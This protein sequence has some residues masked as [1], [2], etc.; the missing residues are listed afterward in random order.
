MGSVSLVLLCFNT[1]VRKKAGVNKPLHS[2]S[3]PARKGLSLEE[4][5]QTGSSKHG[6][7]H[8]QRLVNFSLFIVVIF[9][10]FEIGRDQQLPEE[11]TLLILTQNLESQFGQFTESWRRVQQLIPQILYEPIRPGVNLTSGGH[12]KLPG[13]NVT[14]HFPV[15]LV[16][17]IVSSKLEVWKG[18]ECAANDFRCQY[19]GSTKMLEAILLRKKC[20]LEHIALNQTTG[21]DPDGIKIRAAEGMSAADF[22]IGDYW[23][24]ERVIRNLADIGYDP[25]TMTLE[26]YDWR[27][28]NLNL[29]KRDGFFTKMKMNIEFLVR[30]NEKKVIIVGHSMGGIVVLNFLSWVESKHGGN[31]GPNWAAEHI[32]GFINIAG[33]ILGVPKTVSSLTSGEMRDTAELNAVIEYIKENLISSTDLQ[34]IFRS[35]SALSSM[36]PKGTDKIWGNSNWAPG[37]DPSNKYFTHGNILDIVDYKPELM[38]RPNSELNEHVHIDD[39]NFDQFSCTELPEGVEPMQD[40]LSA[41][42]SEIIGKSINGSMTIDNWLAFMRSVA[43]NYMK[44]VEEHD[45]WGLAREITEDHDHPRY[46]N[47]PLESRL[48]N[49]P[50]MKIYSLYGVGKGTERSYIYRLAQEG[51]SNTPLRIARNISYSSTL[52]THGI[53]LSEGDGTVPLIS[54]GFMGVKGW[55]DPV[56]N[57]SGMKS[58]TKEYAHQPEILSAGMFTDRF[59]GG[60]ATADHVDIMGNH[61]MLTDL[62]LIVS[63]HGDLVEDRIISDIQS[64]ANSIDLDG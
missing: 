56:Y 35:F 11:G 43:P 42:S 47:N 21:L 51:C 15:V 25:D 3:A 57:P 60:V 14:R 58:I 62:L 54:L 34:R 10:A 49:A 50:D 7:Y 55:K 29:E 6:A 2:A 18:R 38:Q 59:R 63:G 46:W 8:V 16:P 24:W 40:E 31:G 53:R 26:P 22:F 61:E 36:I 23:V 33:A 41:T 5:K 12:P 17:G 32:E 37:D 27:L 44:K 52:V 19:W 48:P 28:S 39:D 9:V 13:V 20:W 1:M 45:S 30:R 64:I 4:G